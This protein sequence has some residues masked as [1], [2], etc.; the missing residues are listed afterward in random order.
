MQRAPDLVVAARPTEARTQSR[1]A[2]SQLAQVAS[3]LTAFN[4][5]L[6]R[7]SQ[8]QIEDESSEQFRL[9]VQSAIEDAQ[10]AGDEVREGT[11]D[12]SDNEFFRKGRREQIGR[13]TGHAIRAEIEA[14]YQGWE[15][16]GQEGADVGTFVSDFIA[17]RTSEIDDTDVLAGLQPELSAATNNLLAR[18]ASFTATTLKETS[19]ENTQ[20]EVSNILDK[21]APVGGGP[22]DPVAF[23]DEIRAVRD[24]SIFA[25]IPR[26]EVDE[27]I[28]DAII[29]KAEGSLNEE[30]LAALD[31]PRADGTPPI[32]SKPDVQQR[33]L[34]ARVNIGRNAFN[35]ERNE[36]SVE[37]QAEEDAKDSLE[38][39]LIE[40][41]LSGATSIP[42]ELRIQA[43]DQLG[44]E[45]GNRFIN[46]ADNLFKSPA[47]EAAG[48]TD[49][50]S[51]TEEIF[52]A[53]LVVSGDTQGVQVAIDEG[54][55]PSG[56]ALQYLAGAKAEQ[57]RQVTGGRATENFE[58]R[59]ATR[60]GKIEDERI[61]ALEAEIQVASA[62]ERRGQATAADLA[63]LERWRADPSGFF[64]PPTEG[65]ETSEPEAP[66]PA[67]TVATPEQIEE[68]KQSAA[69][70]LRRRIAAGQDAEEAREA[71]A[72]EMFAANPDLYR[73][74]FNQ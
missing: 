7:I 72:A 69:A 1:A 64:D 17:Q 60:L 34:Q 57:R 28:T 11:R 12:L 35:L 51:S 20:I 18:H 44:F 40:L 23:G 13:N 19:V 39:Q 73:Q 41:R 37:Q 30:F 16:K 26:A 43:F 65:E 22:I 24:I 67:A 47:E 33:I 68:L 6:E 74:V 71:L 14:A 45:A 49:F 59:E 55:I 62:R 36:Q 70:E 58:F 63:L 61:E 42:E 8:K 48:D 15:G 56:R 46:S 21:L 25:G 66:T 53:R 31:A 29:A 38:D 52:A 5:Q 4:P 2:G 10:K 3:A 50:G 27:I 9:G 32:S 54:I